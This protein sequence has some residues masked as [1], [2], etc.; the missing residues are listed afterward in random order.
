MLKA[1]HAV[2]DIEAATAKAEF[3]VGFKN[4]EANVSVGERWA[5][6]L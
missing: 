2:E 5:I 4:E 1:N 3:W 6:C